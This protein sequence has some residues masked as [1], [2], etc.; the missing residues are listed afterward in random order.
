MLWGGKPAEIIKAAER[1]KVSILT[2]EE[3]VAEISQVLAYP[4]FTN[5]CEAEGLQIEDLIEAV[6][7][8]AKFVKVT[9]RINFIVEHPADNKFIE[10]AQ[11]AGADYIVSG[12]KHLL[13]V[14][15]YKKTQLV[16]VNAF[17]QIIENK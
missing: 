15:C 13:K 6:L 17:L 4:K 11:A 9:K 10:C 12:D 5:I 16:S 7:K 3:I 2:S 8:I 1:N 14:V